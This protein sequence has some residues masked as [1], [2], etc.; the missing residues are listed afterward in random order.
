[1]K[2][3][4]EMSSQIAAMFL[5]LVLLAAPQAPAQQA[6]VVPTLVNFSGT[7]TQVNGKTIGGTAGVTFYL[8]K[9]QQGGAPLWIETQNVQPDKYGHYTVML[10]ATKSQGLPTDLFASGEARWLGVQAEGQ[11]EQPRVMLL[12]VPYALKAGDA[13]TVG[14]LPPSA[15][16]LAAP[17][18]VGGNGAPSASSS[19]LSASSP[20][21]KPPVGGTGTLGYLAGWVDNNG[22]LGN[23]VLYQLGTGSTA[24]IGLNLKTPLA[25][26][27]IQGTELVRGLFESATTGTAT[28]TKGFNS[29][30]TDM[31]ASSFNS[32]TN[33]AVMQHFEWQ[34]EPTGNNTTT[35][36]ATL[37]LL[38]GTNNNTPAETGLLFGNTGNIQATNKGQA[39]T[40]TMTGNNGLVG[41]IYGNAT[42]NGST[43]GV[44]GTST[45]G[46]GVFGTGAKAGTYGQGGTYGAY[47]TSSG[48]YGTYGASVSGTGAYGLS[49]NGTGVYGTGRTNGV[50]GTASF[51]NGV[52]GT[53]SNGS[54]VNGVGT[55]PDVVGVSGQGGSNSFG[56]SGQGGAAGVFGYANNTGFGVEGETASGVAGVSGTWASPS[57]VGPGNAG[58]WGDSSTSFG[59]VATSGDHPGL[60]AE[61]SQADGIDAMI[62]S[63]TGC[64]AV[65]GSGSNGNDAGGYGI[66][67]ENF[68]SGGGQGIV[69]VSYATGFVNGLGSD[70]VDG[71]AGTT[72]GSGVAGINTAS[73]G[74]GVYGTT[75]DTSGYAG[76]FD[77]N[78][79]SFNVLS[80][81]SQMKIDHP[82]DPTNK[83]LYHSSVES[84]EMMTMY[85][86]NVTLDGR[87]EAQVVLPSWFEALNRDF[88]YQLTPIGAPGPNLYVAREISGNQFKISGG[89]P[90]SKV[91][92]TVTAARQDAYAQAHPVVVEADKAGSERGTYLHPELYGAAKEA[93]LSW[94]RYRSPH[95]AFKPRSVRRPATRSSAA[96]AKT[97][98]HPTTP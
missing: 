45:N 32:G 60:W 90:G 80:S 76:Y 15:F 98:Q 25:S 62:D 6:S 31:E 20:G 61:S 49:T 8:Y 81:A 24:K 22:D 46:Y 72:S 86:G 36:G 40:A 7:L 11:V 71:I 9:D 97:A 73:G 41:A 75:P 4:S 64:A 35:P 67:G 27:D 51:G 21:V 84:S 69:G 3:F 68:N 19:P 29:N 65:F 89:K 13:Q 92:W 70:G 85:S 14:G 93:G 1:M 83:Y 42:G 66:Y 96:I 48:G 47:G 37:N 2:R 26:L 79:F 33:A 58:V 16:V 38:F 88:R 78:I 52:Y 54:G 30:A 82:A 59:V 57:G 56:V 17:S 53:S 5:A 34:A 91:S 63:C 94:L 50:Y 55:A 44:Q 28:A 10:G 43:I 12:A 87:G 77:G 74:T 18:A 95:P 23:S 39:I